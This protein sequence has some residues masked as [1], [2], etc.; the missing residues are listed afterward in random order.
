MEEDKRQLLAKAVAGDEAFRTALS[1]AADA[2]E[3]ARIARQHGI[4]ADAADFLA[5]DAELSDAELEAASGGLTW[6]PS[7]A[8]MARCIREFHP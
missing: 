3:A 2:D 7:A 6:M 4:P 8:T 1:A 5:R